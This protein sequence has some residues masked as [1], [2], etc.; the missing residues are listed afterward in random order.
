MTDREIQIRKKLRD[1]LP[2][3][4]LKCLK[5]RAKKAVVSEG[6]PQKIIPF[7]LN[8]AQ[9][10]VD[11]RLKQQGLEIGKI[12]ALILKGR[13]QGMSTYIGARYYQK[14]SHRE[15]VKTFIL[16]HR[17]DATNN[18]FSMVKRFHKH[19]NP[20]VTPSTSHSNR[21][22]LVFDKLDSAY[23]LGTAGGGDVGRSDTID[24]FHGSEVA[25]WKNIQEIQTGVFQAANEAEEIILESTANG[26]DPMF[27]PMWQ[28]AESGLSE[29]I[30][31]FVA[32]FWQP[33]YKLALPEGWEP[34]SD[35]SEMFDLYNAEGLTW[36]HIN[37]R[38][39]KIASEFKGDNVLFFQ[40]YPCTAAEA[41]QVT[42]HD[43]FIQ[44]NCV[45]KARKNTNVIPTGAHIVGCDPARGGDNTCFKHRQGRVA[46]AG[47]KYKTKDTKMIIGE[48]KRLFTEP[49]NPENPVDY[50]FIDV[51]GL[52]GP[53]YDFVKDMSFGPY[54]IPVNFGSTDVYNP[55][56]FGNCRAEMWGNMKDWLEDDVFPPQVEDSDSLQSDCCAPG[57]R[58]DNQQRIFL[59][60]KEDMAKRGQRSPDEG[61]A[62]ALTF[63]KPVAP[64]HARAGS[65]DFVIPKRRRLA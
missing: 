17:D 5:I 62:L 26:F 42:G 10:Y 48:I 18:L 15:G 1:N 64:R 46:W 47:K 27:H 60:K 4:A 3:F 65:Q 61:D 25:F 30:A 63:A 59:E 53:L 54:V 35:E 13:Q 20:L 12:R 29:Y 23:S 24:Y 28:A 31:I 43:S 11:G 6:R 51:G 57:Y 40:E 19:N 52:G 7:D 39:N 55:E 45:I 49:D 56:R 34:T 58:Y 41:F 32:W 2:H 38:R 50:L 21:K 22:E 33:E 9:I 8:K 14:T 16:T 37:W 44:P 36:E